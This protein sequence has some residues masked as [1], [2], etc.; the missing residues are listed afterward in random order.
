[1]S[2]QLTAPRAP[3]T[4][5]QDLG[6]RTASAAI[7]IPV[8]LIGLIAGGWLWTALVVLFFF[9]LLHEWRALS[10]FET[11]ERRNRFLLYGLAYA[12]I[13][14]LAVLWLRGRRM[15]GL[16][17]VLFLLLVVWMTDI[18]AYLVGRLIGGRK[19]AP[20]I[21]PGKTISGAIGGLI[22]GALAGAIFARTPVAFLPAAVLSLVSQVGDLAESALKRHLGVKDSGHTIPGHGGLFD[23]LDGILAAAPVAA[24]LAL[25]VHGGLP[26]WR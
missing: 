6:I 26:L 13:P 19:L 20:T 18:G 7:L 25:L 1:M 15:I 11:P 17:D 4:R 2:A 14:A 22:I 9:G 12:A 3:R 24:L 23:R 10:H 8:T 5:F 16:D 21:S